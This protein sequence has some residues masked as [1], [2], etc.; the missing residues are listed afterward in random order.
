MLEG[1]EGRIHFVRYTPEMEQ[2]RAQGRLRTNSFVPCGACLWMGLPPLRARTWAV[3]M[4][5]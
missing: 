1:T 5:S 4:T 3:R 2:A